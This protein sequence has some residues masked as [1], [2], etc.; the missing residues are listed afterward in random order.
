[1]KR[2]KRDRL[3]EAMLVVGILLVVGC[4]VVAAVAL[5]R[6][7]PARTV[8]SPALPNSALTPG[9]VFRVTKTEVCVSGYTARVRSVPLS[10]RKK[11]FAEYGIAYA[12][13]AKYEVDHLIS[14]ELG[15]SNDIKNLWPEPYAGAQGA[16]VKDKVE[17]H[18]HSLV[19]AGTLSL[20]TAQRAIASNWTAVKP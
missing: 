9:A 18:L 13:R 8:S 20:A 14:L 10:V 7:A 17:N 19:C 15:G 1:M 2:M 16:R 6:P 12:D 3:I 5:R 4:I 11:V